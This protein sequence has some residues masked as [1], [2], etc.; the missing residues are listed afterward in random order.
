MSEALVEVGMDL[1][2]YASELLGESDFI[3]VEGELIEGAVRL[4]LCR[5]V[6]SVGNIRDCHRFRTVFLTDP[7]GIRKVDSN[8]GRRVA[9]ACEADCVDDL[10][11][12][13]L[14]CLFLESRVDR[15]I[16][17]K[18]LGICTENL[19]SCRCCGVFNIDISLP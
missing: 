8:R 15:G 11:G 13:A 1:V 19:S 9:V 10:G 16:V 17:L 7:V 2:S 6:I 5:E 18:P 3:L 14:H 4:L 12:D